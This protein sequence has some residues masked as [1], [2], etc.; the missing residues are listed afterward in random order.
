V[1][2]ARGDV[3]VREDV[4]RIVAGCE[5]ALAGVIHAAGVLADAALPRQTAEG[6]DKVMGPKVVDTWSLHEATR[7][8]QRRRGLGAGHAG[9]RRGWGTGH[10]ARPGGLPARGHPD[11]G[12]VHGTLMLVGPAEVT[13]EDRAG[14]EPPAPT[15]QKGKSKAKTKAKSKSP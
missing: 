2:V 13:L 7:R 3:G 6:V 15:Q 9:A 5:A 12:A 14:E 11:P 10:P 1:T 4:D 8:A